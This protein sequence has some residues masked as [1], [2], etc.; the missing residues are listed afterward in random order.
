[1]SPLAS[2]PRVYLD[3]RV[4]MIPRDWDTKGLVQLPPRLSLLVRSRLAYARTMEFL[5]TNKSRD[6]ERR[7]L[8]SKTSPPYLVLDE[9][10]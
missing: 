8:R 3:I 9:L 10:G 2:N 5:G 4:L 1:M 7:C 6:R